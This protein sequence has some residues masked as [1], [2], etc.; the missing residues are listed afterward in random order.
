MFYPNHHIRTYCIYLGSFK[1][2]KQKVDFGV[3][4]RN[5]E[6]S[7]AIVFG[8]EDPEYISGEFIFNG[9]LLEQAFRFDS[10]L[11]QLNE[12]LYQEYLKEPSDF[13]QP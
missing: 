11:P 4:K 13:P 12:R 10:L 5:D 6:V 9:K 7:H 1:L 8:N 3:Y 2:D